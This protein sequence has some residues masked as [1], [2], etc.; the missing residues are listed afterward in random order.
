M[1]RQS[2]VFLFCLVALS[3]LACNLFTFAPAESSTVPPETATQEGQPPPTTSP[4]PVPGET[5][6]LAPKPP[7]AAPPAPTDLNVPL[8]VHNP[9]DAA[10][11][12]EPVTSGVPLPRDLGL[13]DPARL[14][15]VSAEGD[16]IPAQ[17]TPLVRWGG[18]AGL[19]TGGAPDDSA[20]PIRW[21]LVDFQATVGPRDTVYY[22]LQE[23]GLGHAP[24]H[25]PVISDSADGIF[26]HTLHL[27]F[28][29]RNY[30]FLDVTLTVSNSLGSARIGEPVTSGVPI[31]RDVN[32]IDLGPLRLLD[33]SGQ[34]IAAQFT[35]LARWGGSAGLTTGGSTGLTTGSA[36]DDTSQPVRWL[37][38]DFQADVPANTAAS[39]RLVG[40][41]TGM[42][43]YPTLSVTDTTSA[44]A[45]DAGSAQFSI[46]K[47]DGRLTGPHL[48]TPLVGRAIGPGGAVYT[49]TGP[50]TVTV[51]LTGP[52]RVSVHVRGAYRDASG[53]PLLAYTS[54]YWFYAGQPI[55]RLFHTVENNN[56]CPLVEYG[57]LDCYDI[58]SGGSVTVT[59]LSLVLSTDL[60]GDLTYRAAGEGPP[61]S[62]SLTDELLL[63]QDSSGTD[64]WD[65]YPTFTDWFSNPLDTR[66]RLQSYVS[67][68]GYSTTLGTTV[69][70][71]GDHAAGWLSV[72]GDG[73][74]WTVGVRDFWQ[75]FPKALRAVPDGTLEIAL[76][77]NEF[78]PADY[79][80]NLRA[81]EHKTHEIILSPDSPLPLWGEGPG[82]GALFASA[83][84]VWYIQSGAFSFL[85]AR[86]FADWPDHENYINHQ[87]DT[88]PTYEDWMDWFPNLPAAIESTDFYGLFDYGDWPIDYEGYGVAPLN[89]KYDNDYGL[90]LQWARTGDPRWFGLAEA[91]DRHIADVDILHNVHSPRHWGDGIAFGH[92]HHDEDGFINPHRNYGGNHP[93]TAF[94]V[95]GM[96]LTYYL[97]GYEKALDSALELA[98]CIEYRLHNDSHLCD[99]FPPG[100]CSGEGY[101]L[102][103]SGGL[104]DAGSRPAANGLSLAVAAYRATADPRYLAVAD[105][106]VD[107]AKASDQ[108]YINGPTGEDRMMR[109]WMLNMYLRALADYLE[110]RAEF[111]STGLTT[112]GLPD[113][114]DA[115]G[116][117]LAYANWLR[118]YAWLDLE[119]I[120]TGPRA[121]YP[122]EWWF[123]ERTGIPGDDNDNDDLSIC[124]WLLLGADAMAYAHYLSGDAD[125]LERAARLFRTGSRD[126]WFE[127]DANTYSATKETTNGITFGHVF[128]Y[129]WASGAVR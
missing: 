52:M 9:L 13:T 118:T 24:A 108:P 75:N 125:Y 22:F 67:F 107:W 65:L 8:Q 122:Y 115:E 7:P 69:V 43:T 19:T 126:P 59:D 21:V 78:G 82:E 4:L 100:E 83:P 104:Y 121:A 48:A 26:T 106:V 123:D 36:P 60:G 66:P 77:P 34:P 39:Y 114:Y 61:A 47:T 27:P 84:P 94:G 111:G 80:F 90:W 41:G 74:S 28:A 79:G 63:Y 23:D 101:G 45:V 44:V 116:S 110:M 5:G 1:E 57:Q 29:L 56:L 88:A 119:A 85:S 25:P 53:A 30:A 10:R 54:R 86:D 50:V 112:G 98:D 11:T 38:L 33:G 128:L 97:T 18:S 109:P 49:T 6:N 92:S 68:R 127:E 87:L 51:R 91:A 31:P 46:S 14:R 102:G 3:A 72:A 105:A 96:L 35:P 12:D 20:A 70:D 113:T 32:L 2:V 42:P 76:F 117:F 62:G 124:N 71:S 81:G 37:L 120:D 99:F 40:G 93:D 58:G 64:H 55:V 73:G 89:S 16:P 15:L 103:E 17:F 95:A 129:E